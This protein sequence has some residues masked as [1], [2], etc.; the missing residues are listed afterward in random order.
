MTSTIFLVMAASV[1]TH[2]LTYFLGKIDGEKMSTEKIKRQLDT[3][4][5]KGSFAGTMKTI[6][7]Y[8][9]AMNQFV[10]KST[11]DDHGAYN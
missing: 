6:Q 2:L 10:S 1:A 4:Y 7:T 3:A 5:A 11:D 9:D 8:R